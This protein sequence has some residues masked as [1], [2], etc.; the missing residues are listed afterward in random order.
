VVVKSPADFVGSVLGGSEANT[1][2]ILTSTVGK[3]LIIDEAYMLASGAMGDPYKVAVIDTI[4]AEVQSTPGEDRSVLLLGY[5][6]QVEEMFRDVNPGLARRFPLESAFVFEDFDD[7]EIRCIL[8]LKLKDIGSSGTDQAKKVAMDVIQRARNRPNFGNAG[9]IDTILDRAKALHQKHMTAGKLKDLDTFEA[10]DFNPNFD[11]GERAATNLPALFQDIV[12]CEDLIKQFQGYQT[13]A[14]NMKAI[15]MDPR[16]QLPF[17]FLLKGPPGKLYYIVGSTS[18]N[19][20]IGTGKTTTAQKMGK[21]FY[22]TGLLSQAKVVECSATDLIGQYVGHTGPKFQK[23]IEKAMGKVLFIDEACRLAEDG[24]ALEAMDESVDC[25]TKPKFFGKLITI[26]AGYDKD[27]DRLMRINPGL[28]SRFPETVF[29]KRLEPVTSMERLV[30]VLTDVQKRKKAPLDISVLTPPSTSLYEHVIELFRQLSVLD[31]WGH[32]R[33][34]KS[35]AR[36]MFQTLISTAV[37][38]VTSLVLTEEIVTEVMEKTLEERSQRNESVGTLRFP[39]KPQSVP[40]LPQ[41]LKPPRPRRGRGPELASKVVP[42]PVQAAP[43]AESVLKTEKP[44]HPLHISKVTVPVGDPK[45][46]AENILAAKRDYG[47]LEAVW[48]QLEQDKHAWMAKELKYRLLQEEKRQEE[49]E[50]E[51]LKR[52]EIQAADNEERRER[53]QERIAPELERRRKQEILAAMEQARETEAASAK[54]EADGNLPRWIPL[55]SA[56][57][58]V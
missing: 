4:V 6:D 12:G 25:L 32:A 45:D 13:T 31:S 26:L 54:V 42:P 18:A 50:I 34:I 28:T 16:E 27:I 41:Q 14:A 33:D 56:E 57:W 24:F 29:S 15:G 17:N 1:K 51:D 39:N 43:P 23:Q 30:K 5:K 52:A 35:L 55:D 36:S 44:K 2:V 11:R 37:P 19:K 58:W 47:V 49:K 9:E 46:S 48:E 3:V 21:V 40:E 53:E 10:I 7:D 20:H 38:P 8:D 22:D